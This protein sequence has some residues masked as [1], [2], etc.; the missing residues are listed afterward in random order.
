ML[1]H[2]VMNDDR[3]APTT[4]FLFDLMLSLRGGDW[5]HIYAI[6]EYVKLLECAGF[7]DLRVP[8][9]LSPARPSVIL[10][11]RKEA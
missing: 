2:W 11:G 3:T 10:V 9:A 6:G 7:S 8:D 4:S 5:H 1:K